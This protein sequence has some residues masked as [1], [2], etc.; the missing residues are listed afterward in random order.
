MSGYEK[1]IKEVDA[2]K[3]W[4]Q[5]HYQT[6]AS[7]PGLNCGLIQREMNSIRRVSKILKP[8]KKWKKNIRKENLWWYREL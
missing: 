6:D 1:W 4:Y 7:W 2:A 3:P 8:R 5:I